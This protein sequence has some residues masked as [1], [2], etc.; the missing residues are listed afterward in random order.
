M[1]IERNDEIEGK[2]ELPHAPVSP[3]RAVFTIA[4]S[5]GVLYLGIILIR[6]F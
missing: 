5:L 3:Y 2:M 4:I 1:N 6:T